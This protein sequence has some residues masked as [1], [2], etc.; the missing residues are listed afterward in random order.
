MEFIVCC[1]KHY[2]VP[3]FAVTRLLSDCHCHFLIFS[4]RIIMKNI[5]KFYK[6]ADKMFYLVLAIIS[7]A[8]NSTILRISKKF[9]RNKISMLAGNYLTCTLL[10]AA[11]MYPQPFF[12]Q[13]D[14]ISL[15]LFLSAINGIILLSGFLLMQCCIFNYGIVM[16]SIFSRMGVLV[17]ITAAV[18]F[19]RE[20][21]SLLQLLGFALS[22]WAIIIINGRARVK[23][24]S[25]SLIALLLINGCSDL[26]AK[27]YEEIGPSCLSEN[28]LLYSFFTTLVLNIC[29]SIYKKER[30]GIG[31]IAW[32]MILGIPNYYSARFLLKSLSGVP[33]F[34]V[35]PTFSVGSMAALTFIGVLLFKEK[36]DKQKYAAIAV[37]MLSLVLLNI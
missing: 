21:P 28:Y 25:F 35:Y 4:D 19:F 23:K 37:I 1:K 30:P 11:Y 20:K 22:I 17:P 5:V 36:P 27:I 33:A 2:I 8:A 12:P 31:D 24:L 9:I 13:T 6:G 7:A 16:T 18:L 10:S 34:I 3:I 14:K 29:L 15:V 32:G 26:M